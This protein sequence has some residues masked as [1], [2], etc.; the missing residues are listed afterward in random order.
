MNALAGLALL[1]APQDLSPEESL[2]RMKPAEAF[3]VS[4]V[5]SEPQ[6]RQPVTMT[7]DDRGRIWVI[8]YLQYP[9]PAG[10]KAVAVDQYLRT[11]YDRKPEPPP[12]GPKGADRVTILEDAD[13]DGRYETAKDFVTGLNLAS[14]LCL[15]HGG[16]WVAQPPY[17]LFYPDRN[18]DDLPDGD[19]EVCLDGFGMEDAHA[20]A[21]S[22]QWG[23]DG[24]L[25]GTHGST[26]T[27][28]I[29]G[30]EFQQGIWRYHPRTKD[31]ELFAEGGGNTWG[32][33]FDRRGNVIAGTN[34]GGYANLHQVQGAYYVKGFAKHGPLHNPY[35]FGYFEHIPY[36]GFKGGHVTAGGVLYLGGTFPE[37]MNDV[38]IAANPLSNVVN[39]HPL[40]RQGST[41]TARHGG[42]FLAGNDPWFRPIDCLLGPDGAVYVVDWHDARLN[43]VDPRDNWDRRNGRIYRIRHRS[44][45]PMGPL[46]LAKLP[47]EKLVPFLFDANVWFRR[48]A[49]RLMAERRDPAVLPAL[50]KILPTQEETALEALWAIYTTGGFD[51]ALAEA[52]LSHPNEDVRAWTVRLL[53]DAKRVSSKALTKF[54]DLARHDP[55]SAVRCQ[56]ACTAKR[57]P[58]D[59]GLPVIREILGRKEDVDD[60]FIPLLAWW[61]IEDKAVSDR[62][63]VLGLL[64]TAEAWR[65]PLTEKHIVE[66]MARRYMAQGGDENYAA[67]ARL[68]S[69]SPGPAETRRLVDGME[70]ALAGRRLDRVPAPLDKALA[71]LWKSQGQNLK[72][73]RLALR[74]GSAEAYEAALRRAGDAKTPERERIE[75]AEILGEAGKADCVPVLL[76]LLEEAQGDT[77]LQAAISAL[78]P[79]PD[80]KV[81]AAVLA[82]Y[83]RLRGPARSRAQG[84]LA[85]RPASAL[86]LLKLVDAKKLDP[87]E[88]PLDR[89]AAIAQF[90]DDAIQAILRKHWGNV[91]A[92]TPGEKL[93]QIASMKNMI[94][95]AGRGDP[96]KGKPIYT[97][98]CGVCHTF[99]GEGNKIGPELTG[100][101]RK[102][103]DLL[104][105]H[106]VDP[107]AMIRPEHQAWKIRTTNGQVLTG[108]LVDQNPGAVT[109]VDAQNNRTTIA[110][111][112]IEAMAASETSLMPEKLLD[113]LTDDEIRHVLAY[114]QSDTPVASPKEEGKSE[115]LKVCLVSGSL[116]Y[117]SDKSL[118]AFQEYLE[119][120]Y[121]VKC[122][123]AFRKTDEEIP[124]LENLANCDVMLLFT[125]RLK[126][127]G[128]A[129]ERI[130]KYCQSGKPIVG[131]RTASHA[132][133]TWL[134]LDKEVLG[135][136]YTGHFGKGPPCDVKFTEKAKGHPILDGVREFASTGSL[137]KNSSNAADTETLLMGTS[138]GKTEPV[139][140]T[141]LHKGGRI[142]YTSLGD[143]TDFQSDNFRRLLANAL[144]WA[145][146]RA[147]EKKQAKALPG[148]KPLE[149]QGDLAEQ[150]VAGIDKF[151]LREIDAS[152]EKR[153]QYWKRD[154]SSR[155]AYEKSVAPNRERLRRIIGAVDERVKPPVLEY[156]ATTDQ[157]ALVGRGL[158]F[159]VWAVRWPV[160]RGVQGEGLL[161][162]PTRREPLGDAVAIPDADQT[163]EMLAGLVPGLEPD[164]QIARNLAEAGYRVV[165]PTL[166]DRADTYSVSRIGRAT[167]QPHR[168]FVY[169]PAFEL[170]RH[171]IGYEVQKVLAAVDWFR[172]ESHGKSST[173]VSGLGEGGLLALYSA[174]V[175]PRI[176]AIVT[177]SYFASR[178]KAWQE[179]IYRNVF[180]L[181]RE[182][183]DAEVASL[184]RPRHLALLGG[185]ELSITGP[186]APR[187]GRAGAAP[188]AWKSPTI[189]DSGQEMARLQ[190]LAAGLE[191]PA[192]SVPLPARASRVPPTHLRKDFDPQLRLKRQLKE[193]LEDTQ[194]L[195]RQSERV[196]DDFFW[197]KIDKKSVEGFERST[198]PLRKVF[199][200]EVNGKFENALLPPN[201]R[202]R[203]VYDEPKYAGYEVVLDV[204]PD[205]FAYGILLVPK[206]VKE[207]ERRPVVVT[208]HGLEGRP[209]HVADPKIDNKSYNQYGCRLAER[210]F[211]VFAPQNPYIGRDAFRTLQRKA[212]LLGRH[213]FSIIIPQH[214]VITDWLASL[215]F[216]DPE[217]IAFYGL[218]YGGKTAM[219]V[220]AVVKRYCLS[221]CSADFNEWIW[222]NAALDS[223]YSYVTTGEYEI[224]EWNLGNTF[225]YAEMAGLI[226]PRPFMV[227]RGHFDGVAPDEKVAYEYAKVRRLYAE[228]KIPDRTEIEF[229]LGPHT[230]HGVGTFE[231][232]H[233]HLRWPKPQ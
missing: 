218:S 155:E 48:E 163:P 141:R 132:F 232:L 191:R 95:K 46:G 13:G 90:K 75:L 212:N 3:E 58:A 143:Q 173:V 160:F 226:C 124:G 148:T 15:G 76:K 113:P 61:A 81:L 50:R 188:G 176:D 161:L 122:S 44:A 189:E 31:F 180:G 25:Y 55:S 11:K 12:R 139:A 147:P 38:Y 98:V 152:V 223:P 57:L 88:I 186:P 116:E 65:A 8:Q 127:A 167:N 96:V 168:E 224:F 45:L 209:Q 208:Q 30:I 151:L 74:L 67:C 125:R 177:G 112:K 227:E 222:K 205:V 135:G 35:T 206:D 231:F 49:R 115:A 62:E 5:A 140:W 97:K 28:N 225:N 79:Y 56:L 109:L 120:S 23:P 134:D 138:G 126:P 24:W 72:V 149:M 6:V 102:N 39:W 99:F 114:L 83:P 85:S 129:L 133:Q 164:H 7:F 207:G 108:L 219:R 86:E 184:I 111:T 37:R 174:A 198:E 1:L 181:L 187:Q 51:E 34:Y 211:V 199:D 228:L 52:T 82:H 156:V 27:A 203:Q 71:D 153:A 170:G 179:P 32:L 106:I 18:G 80:P 16:V 166:I 42:E 131:A 93:A 64:D 103:L 69:M 150:M 183:G 154:T 171:V 53:G 117:D 201:P 128:E 29:R 200:E 146:K 94:G 178:Q 73:L 195:L 119:A 107:N 41:F 118:A 145:S 70:Q 84:F 193:L 194:V 202:A 26:V 78:Q 158:G 204:W 213:L 192:L 230:I 142:F 110:Q 159:E 105:N 101:D 60:R 89:L 123:R 68:L 17:L 185:P 216:V 130:R 233:K 100:Q 92:A 10:L 77:L 91:G 144:F 2:K 229:F 43:H 217:R 136:S 157:P 175:D 87:K 33:D 162:L 221:I 104:L 22:L 165:V 172:N 21:N 190:V 36:Q 59:Q 9:N 220:P 137:Y 169:R 197:K 40:E 214:Q 4:L 66:R 196:R 63:R 54:V 19:P 47:T 20:F 121:N 215:P 182:F 210:G 14:G